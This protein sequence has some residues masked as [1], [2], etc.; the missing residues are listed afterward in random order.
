MKGKYIFQSMLKQI[1]C[2]KGVFILSTLLLCTAFLVAGY[3]TIIVGTLYYQRYVMKDMVE[4]KL[5]NVYFL[6]LWRYKMP[7]QDEVMKLAKLNEEI[8]E[9]E[10]IK[11]SGI[12]SERGFTEEN[13]LAISSEL[14]SLCDLK[15]IEGNK[16]TLDERNGKHAAIVGYN[17]KEKYPIGYEFYDEVTEE[18]FVVTEVLSKDSRWLQGAVGF[19]ELYINL[20]DWVLTDE[21][22]WLK[23]E[24]KYLSMGDTFCYI[25]EDGVAGEQVACEVFNAAEKCGIKIYS[26]DNILQKLDMN[27]KDLFSDP[28]DI[29]MAVAMLVLSVVAV[30]V[31]AMI[32]IYLRKSSIGIMYA[33]GYSVL[34][35]RKMIILENTIKITFS[36]LISYSFWK[37]NE[38]NMMETIFSIMD[39]TLPFQIV[40]VIFMIVISS[41]LPAWQ[42]S[43]I[44]PAALI[45][46]KE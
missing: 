10:G 34:D 1:A 9:I 14:L 15:N 28:T 46:G 27:K 6:N 7:S 39:I 36:F 22:V 37:L 24:I 8:K 33:I 40:G 42:L 26:I 45:G 41:I 13:G 20:D 18:T 17:L 35:V 2:R 4:E 38:Q 23:E 16:I 21:N 25:I 30:V 31:S 3:Q 19:A 29:L 5:D 43:R 32:N 11:S 12:Y 44:Y